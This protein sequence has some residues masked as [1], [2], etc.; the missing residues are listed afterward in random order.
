[1]SRPALR[2]PSRPPLDVAG[3]TAVV[4]GAAGGMGEHIAR[5][6]G[7][8]GAHLALVDRDADGLERV[9]G[10]VGGE[11]PGVRVSTYV[12]DLSDRDAVA[13][14]AARLRDAHPDVRVL[15]NNAGV[16]LG[17]RF[18]Q[19]SEADFDWLLEVNLHTPIRLTRALLPLMIEN[20]QGQVVGLS[21]LFGLVGPAG[22]TAYSTSKFGLRGFNESL[23]SELDAEDQPVG[24]TSVHPGGI[25]TNIARNARTASGVD[26]D[27]AARGRRA[28][29][30]ALRYPAD[31]AAEEIVEAL[32][33]RRRRLLV[34]NDARALDALARVAPS[35]YWSVMQ[36][37]LELAA[38]RS[39]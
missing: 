22:Q 17:G 23:A 1:M 25:A 19:T 13:A 15:V 24:V 20:G 30:K 18:V 10:L 26:P 21:S 37:G 4:T 12:A 32:V 34:G 39:R 35:G 16:A 38:R 36:R 27:E 7:R 33:A 11:S 2:R 14:L 28:F 3:A 6:L 8:R 9:A 31:K 5:G 29:D